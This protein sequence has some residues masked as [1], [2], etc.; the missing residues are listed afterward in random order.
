MIWLMYNML[1]PLG[2]LILL[3]KFL[4]RMCRRGGYAP[5]FPQ[6]LG[7]YK[8]PVA[9]RLAAGNRIWIQAV[10]VGE[11]F[12][13]LKLIRHIRE[14]DPAALFVLSTNTSTGYAIGHQQIDDR[15]VLI[16][17][18]L[19]FPPIMRRV[20]G[21]LKPRAMLLIENEMWP[22][23]IR[24]AR[25][26]GIPVALINGRISAHSYR[27][28]QRLALF[29]R[30]LLPLIDLFC[31]QSQGDAERLVALGAPSDRVHVMGSAKYDV[32]EADPA[33]EAAA[34]Q[35]LARAGVPDDA[36]ILLGGSTWEGEEAALLRIFTTLRRKHPRLF[37]LL[38]PRHVERR[39]QIARLLDESGCRWLRRS[40]VAE[41]PPESPT[42]V[43]FLDTTGELKNFYAQAD[44]IFVG[45]SLTRHGGQN[46]IEPA[47]HGK[48]VLIGPN[49]E[50]FSDVV[51][52]LLQAKAIEQVQNETGLEAAIDRL[53]GDEGMRAEQGRRAAEAVRGRAGTIDAT[54]LLLARREIL[55][56]GRTCEKNG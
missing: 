47:F 40:S 27:G 7:L 55:S 32:V 39:E 19:D 37:L 26:R 38:A 31:T 28:Y 11:I 23:M 14:R 18:P 2:L 12:V 9:A 43:L 10:S 46:P 54:V 22:N 8:A 45:K 41:H 49:M 29:T 21:L 34:R 42:N 36:I 15:D 25:R 35:V 48:P 53:A 6:R 24:Q 1:F 52:E 17:F 3:P 51:S 20:L 4:F 33:G 5:D 44:I 56:R 50:N 16:Y 30:R 13:A